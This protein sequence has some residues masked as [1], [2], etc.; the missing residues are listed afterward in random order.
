MDFRKHEEMEKPVE[1]T[2][3]EINSEEEA[4]VALTA[5]AFSDGWISRAGNASFHFG[6][7]VHTEKDKE[8]LDFVTKCAELLGYRYYWDLKRGKWTERYWG[9]ELAILLLT[10]G[11]PLGKKSGD[12][13]IPTRLLEN[14]GY[15][16]YGLV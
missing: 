6:I 4:L 10:A 9:R 5:V 11:A 15:G 14:R 3:I 16:K 2:P 7:A 1:I 12:E 13:P 8:F